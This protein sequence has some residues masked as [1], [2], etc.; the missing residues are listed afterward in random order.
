MKIK[1]IY[2]NNTKIANEL[3][4]YH[5]RIGTENLINVGGKGRPL[6]INYRI[7]TD[8]T[9][10]D[11][12]TADTI[13]TIYDNE[14]TTFSLGHVLRVMSGD[15]KQTLTKERKYALER[16]IQRLSETYLEIDCRKEL[17]ARGINWENDGRIKGIFLPLSQ[18][19]K[20]TYEITGRI[21]L[22]EYAKIND[23]KIYFPPELL[24]IPSD[25]T[26]VRMSNTEELLLIKYYLIRRL[27]LMRHTGNSMNERR[28]I[29]IHKSHSI[30]GEQAG[31]FPEI[32]LSSSDY[33]SEASWKN[34][35]QKV[36]QNICR[37]L[38]YYQSIGY[39]EGYTVEK[40]EYGLV[41]GVKIEGEIRNAFDRYPILE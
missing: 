31:L 41:K 13:C 29:Y 24:R 25:I 26:G 15:E 28:I 33:A 21:P 3:R 23:Q 30:P 10:F 9:P 19:G 1:S 7:D 39:I 22:Y 32:G 5:N 12:M 6:K 35:R 38:N 11:Y 17:K 16:S 37:I 40:G 8:L 34:K 18:K 27:E 2:M 20:C 4:K 14:Y 36:H